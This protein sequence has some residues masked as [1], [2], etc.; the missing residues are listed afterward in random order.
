MKI[1]AADSVCLSLLVYQY[2]AIIF[3]SRM[4]GSQTNRRKKQNRK[5]VI[6]GHSRSRI[7]GSLKSR[8]RTAC[9]YIL[10]L[11]LSLKF[12]KKYAEN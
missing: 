11:A 3:E 1:S 10:L 6:Q 4:F 12:P 9:R 8:R 7:L 2:H 5:I